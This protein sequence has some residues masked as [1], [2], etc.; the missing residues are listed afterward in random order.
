M[1]VVHLTQNLY[2]SV[3]IVFFEALGLGVVTFNNAINFLK[4]VKTQVSSPLRFVRS[5]V[6]LA[7]LFIIVH[8]FR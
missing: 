8:K 2:F 4:F 7:V 6:V 5:V 1:P 3:F